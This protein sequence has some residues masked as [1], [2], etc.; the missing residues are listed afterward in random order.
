[1]DLF[2]VNVILG[3]SRGTI[4]DVAFQMISKKLQKEITAA[5]NITFKLL[6]IESRMYFS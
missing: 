5:K 3:L 2:Q 6:G 4:T 1:M